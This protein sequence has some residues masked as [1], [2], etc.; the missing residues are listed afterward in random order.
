MIS[1]KTNEF[2]IIRHYFNHPLTHPAVALGIGDDAALVDSLP[3][4]QWAICTD[5]LVSGVHFPPGT[6]SENVGWKSVAVNLSDLAAMGATPAWV[7]LA[8]TLPDIDHDW[9]TGFSQGLFA[10]CDRH[11]VN[12]IGGDLTSGPLSI[13]IQ[14]G[15]Y[16]PKGSALLRQGARP[17]DLI[18]VTGSLGDAGAGLAVAQNPP[19]IQ[20][21]DH[22]Y[23]LSRLNRP[24]PR[25]ATGL[26]LRGLANS[27]LDISDGLLAD[28]NHIVKASQ[29][30]A[31]VNAGQLP[32]SAPLR[33]VAGE[34]AQEYALTAGDDYELCFTL[35]EHH[36]DALRH[37]LATLNVDITPIGRITSE[38]GLVVNDRRRSSA[39]NQ[40]GGFLH[41]K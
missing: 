18:C 29:C 23:L 35:P 16:L 37:E 21:E 9:L 17:D 11:G 34:Q 7:T 25:V 26:R 20:T 1:S 38:S 32:L 22:T 24:T 36:L 12:L 15:G 14:A 28:L 19:T 33:A 27:C 2:S 13:T 41:F 5:T 8:L 4:R 31:I 6:S 30:G 40:A 39:P 3:G 10:L